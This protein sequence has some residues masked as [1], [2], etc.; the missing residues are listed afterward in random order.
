[1]PNITQITDST[2]TNAVKLNTSLPGSSDAALTVREAAQGQ[3]TMAN[4]QPVVLAS[5]QTTI[6]V[7]VSTN[8]NSTSGGE[9]AFTRS[10]K[11]FDFEF[12]GQDNRLLWYQ[13][14]AGSATGTINTAGDALNMT[15]TTASGDQVI[16]QT[17][18]IMGQSGVSMIWQITCNM[19]A[20]KTNVRQR[21]GIFDSNDGYFF[22]QNGTNLRVVYRTSTSGSPVDTAV[23]QSNWN[24]DKLDGTG[25]SGITLTTSNVNTYFITYN[26]DYIQFGIIVNGQAY[27][28]HRINGANILTVSSIVSYNL[29]IRTEITNT[30]TAS[31]STTFVLYGAAAFASGGT[32]PFGVNRAVDLG[33]TGKTV[34]NTLTPLISL[35]LKSSNIR[36]VIIPQNFTLILSSSQSVLFQVIFN[37]TLT[38][39][40]FA[41][42]PGTN[43]ITEYDTSA[44]AISGGD[45]IYSGYSS[46]SGNSGTPLAGSSTDV[47]NLLKISSNIAG[48]SDIITWAAQKTGGTSPTA[49]L[50]VLYRELL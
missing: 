47:T 25:T 44:T 5:D 35:R 15:C 29:P 1:M 27:Y 41:T 16:R 38:G 50:S 11:L 26:L 12:L 14:L 18:R 36:N 21:A 9:P 48:T 28:C 10:F 37:G 46:G 43:T 40:S 3:Q 19:G 32:A 24:V 30:G 20:I 13:T 23:E 6:P 31:S 45:I 49:Y 17:Q 8:T 2:N 34:P 22:E 7:T 33:I 39:A 4:S 42:T